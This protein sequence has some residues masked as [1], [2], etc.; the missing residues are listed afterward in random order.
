MSRRIS[1]RLESR[2]E[3]LS[4]I[5]AAVEDM[6]VS[7]DWPQDFTF[8]IQLALEEL[9]VNVINYGHSEENPEGHEI[10][11][12][13]RSDEEALTIEIVD[14][15]Q[16]FDPVNDAP[17]PDIDAGIEDRPIGGLGV[18]LVQKM[19]DEMRYRR[20]GDRNRLTLVKRKGE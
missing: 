1:L 13:M 15:G 4:R 2:P 3:E 14:D 8:R 18:F 16:P 11:V 5:E 19:M 12:E 9:I 17:K 20:D 10:E 6:A 7:E